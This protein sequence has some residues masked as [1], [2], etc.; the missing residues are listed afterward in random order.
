MPTFTGTSAAETIDGS[1][2][3]DIIDGRGGADQLDGLDGEDAILYQVGVYGWEGGFAVYQGAA[4][5]DGGDGVDTFDLR[6]GYLSSFD[7]YIYASPTFEGWVYTTPTAYTLGAGAGGDVTFTWGTRIFDSRDG[8]ESF[9]ATP[10][11]LRNVETAVFRFTENPNVPDPYFVLAG[12]GRYHFSANDRLII[13]DLAGTALTGQIEFD[14]G[15]GDDVLDASAVSNVIL[16]LGGIGRDDLRG[17]SA[18]DQLYGGDGSDAL[19]GG[20]GSNVLSGGEGIDLAAYFAATESVIID[21]ND[22][23]VTNNGYGSVDSLDGIE[24]LMGGDFNDVLIGEASNNQLWGGAGSDYLVGL[25]GN[26]ILEGGTGAANTL[27]GGLGDDTYIV[28]VAGDTVL[29]LAGEGTDSVFTTVSVYR[30]RDNIENLTFFGAGGFNGLGNA[31]NNDISGSAGA[32]A[33]FGYAGNDVLRGD[34]GAANT[35][36]GGLGDDR[37]VTRVAGDTLIEAA[38]EGHDTVETTATT[39]TLRDN[40]EDLVFVPSGFSTAAFA[41]TGNALGN[42][43]QGASAGD[44]LSGLAGNDTLRGFDGTDILRGGQGNDVLDG[45][46]GIDTV[47]YAA[48]AAGVNVNLSGNVAANDGDGGSDSLLGI[49]NL[50]GSAFNDTLAGSAVANVL[51][52]GLG[53]D[54]LIGLGG[55]DVLEGGTGAANTLI[56]GLGDDLYRVSVAGDTLVESAGQG[57]DTVETTVSALT[58]RANFEDLT[59]TGTGSFSGTGNAENNSITGGLSADTL[60]GLGGDDILQGGGSVDTVVM[61]GVRADYQINGGSSTWTIT[62]LVAGRDGTDSLLSIERIRFSD[63]SILDLTAPAAPAFDD[64]AKGDAAAPLTLPWIPWDEY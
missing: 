58:L 59:F 41:G 19:M 2:T 62:D 7:H 1:A 36:I 54:T 5:L 49:E 15:A 44:I 50:T 31:L 48:A 27:Q 37:Y 42:L 32:D 56:G 9:G 23:T 28:Q 24:S 33:L 43:I 63:G 16:A 40:F 13:S 22:G 4:V 55:N 12:D 46:A 3:D 60:I 20:A 11:T 64:H 10:V 57:R 39:Y 17:G 45:G 53:A 6:G 52:G 35:L 21:L 61:S 51:R 8:S 30:L 29:E 18:D 25:G 14:G 26:D 34:A 38:G 47:D